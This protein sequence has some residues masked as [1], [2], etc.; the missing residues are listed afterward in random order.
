MDQSTGE[1]GTSPA[2]VTP[3]G[4]VGAGVGV[5]VGTR[6]GAGVEAGVGVGVGAGVGVDVGVDVGVGVGVEAGVGTGVGTGVGAGVGAGVEAGGA[7]GRPRQVPCVHSPP[8]VDSLVQHLE[9]IMDEVHKTGAVAG[10]TQAPS[11]VDPARR[12]SLG[13]GS[14]R[15]LLGGEVAGGDGSTHARNPITSPHASSGRGAHE[16][17]APRRRHSIGGAVTAHTSARETR[18]GARGAR[19]TAASA[20]VLHDLVPSCSGDVVLA[21]LAGNDRNCTDVYVCS[22]AS[23]PQRMPHVEAPQSVR[24]NV[25]AEDGILRC[26]AA[27]CA[28]STRMHQPTQ[29]GKHVASQ[30]AGT[31]CTRVLHMLLS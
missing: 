4:G 26:M 11:G 13:T 3:G 14:R 15:S 1:A 31:P 8:S 16:T 23:C 17:P 28:D 29:Q 2:A 24:R 5:G 10:P 30:T 22:A 6:V 25:G 27:A 20:K 21:L 12:P 18:A 9:A 19:R 7:G